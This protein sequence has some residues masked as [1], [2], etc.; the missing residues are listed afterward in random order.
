M[1]FDAHKNF[2]VS[3]VA[4]APSPATSGL[5]LTLATGG[6]ALMPATPFNASVWPVGVIPL[7]TNAEI[8]RVTVVAGDVLTIT[9]A[10]ETGAGGPAAR[11]IVVGDQIAATI[12]AK[13]V[14]DL[15]SNPTFTGLV[16][17]TGGLTTTAGIS[18]SAYRVNGGAGAVGS[19]DMVQKSV[20]AI[21]NAVATTVLTI[22]IPN[23]AHSAVVTVTVVGSLGAGG[24]IGAN[25]ASAANIY[26]ITVTR[27]AG[28]NAVATVSAASGAAAAAVAGATTM[29]ATLTAAAVSGAVGAT[30][31]IALQITITRGGGASTN[32]TCQVVASV[33]NANAAGVTVA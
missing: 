12:T 8:V 13:T 10:Q 29:T 32:H 5:S 14:T 4:V 15:E 17:A 16:T 3:T 30:N 9:R 20:A 1:A 19:V 24:A 25:E 27:T 31:T 23:A 22:T 6:G 21:A 11:A 26:S 2:A 33:L 28:V 7:P 18:S